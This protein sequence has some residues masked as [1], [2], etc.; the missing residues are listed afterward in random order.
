MCP[1][2]ESVSWPAYHQVRG[3]T[4]NCV[5][6]DLAGR[7]PKS[8]CPRPLPPQDSERSPGRAVGRGAVFGA[9]WLWRQ[10]CLRGHSACAPALCPDFPFEGHGHTGSR[11]ILVTSSNLTI[12]KHLVF[13]KWSHSQVTE[14]QDFNHGFWRHTR[15]K[16][17]S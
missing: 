14:G 12:Y 13:S 4:R 11:P 9:A 2:T 7:R 8:R 15:N 3:R 10:T 17:N 1:C 16:M 5:P 6:P